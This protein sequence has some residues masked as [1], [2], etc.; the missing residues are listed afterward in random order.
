[1]TDHLDTLHKVDYKNN[2]ETIKEIRKLRNELVEGKNISR[3]AWKS[4]NDP[5]APKTK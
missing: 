1:M 4:H 2:I 3:N 5:R